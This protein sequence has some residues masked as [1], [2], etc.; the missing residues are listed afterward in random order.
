M[1]IL[2]AIKSGF[3]RALKTWNG[4][5]I[6][7]FISL[8]MVSFLVV[9]LKAS[10]MASFGNSMVTEK[11]MH[12][13][14]IDV[15][16]DLGINL[17]SIVSSLFSGILLL[18]GVAIILNAFITGGLF[19]S[20]KN[21]S[22]RVTSE[23]FF[24]ASAKNFWSF[25]VISALLYLIVICLI[26][27]LIALPVSIAARAESS[28]EGIVFRTLVVSCIIFLLTLS[29]IFLVADYARAC[30]VSWSQNAYFK[31]LGYGFRQSF[32]TFFSSFPLMIIMLILQALLGWCMIKIIAVYTPVTGG[33]VFLFFIISQLLFIL[34]IFLKVLRYGS[35]IS[36]MEQNT[37]EVTPGMKNPVK[38]DRKMSQDLQM[39]LNAETDADNVITLNSL[40][41]KIK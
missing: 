25:L 2:S 6:S 13:I 15:L 23:N 24:R 4:I 27:I 40:K 5:L 26:V 33:G 1:K 10:L 41:Y 34:K 18:A 37:L 16:G 30:Q 39:G 9:P 14:N 21:H 35:V 22:E 20:L 29:I 11:L 32:R 36:L 31:V 12:G 7:W 28:R 38:S 17:H 3:F 19:D 8:L